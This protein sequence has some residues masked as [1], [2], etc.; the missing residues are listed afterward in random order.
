MT[1]TSI[2]RP[3]F[4]SVHSAPSQASIFLALSH[5]G[6]R[7]GI[8][9]VTYTRS[10]QDAAYSLKQLQQTFVTVTINLIRI[11]QW[12]R[13]AANSDGIEANCQPMPLL[14]LLLYCRYCH[15]LKLET[16]NCLPKWNLIMFSVP[17]KI[18]WTQWHGN[19][20]ILNCTRSFK[21]T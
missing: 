10:S 1:M 6:R 8:D 3:C 9:Q 4:Q 12:G 11:L 16:S 7:H 13:Y 19:K 2:F 5:R 14:L 18:K 15:T 21:L 20:Q 17:P